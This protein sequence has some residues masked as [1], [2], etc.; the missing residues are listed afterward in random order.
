[1]IAKTG[2]QTAQLELIGPDPISSADVL[3]KAYRGG[4]CDSDL[5]RHSLMMK[6]EDDDVSFARVSFPHPI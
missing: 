2:Q 4:A 6:Y 1:M 3:G 5:T